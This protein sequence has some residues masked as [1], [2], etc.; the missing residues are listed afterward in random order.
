MS[1]DGMK[2]L[3]RRAIEMWSSNNN[4]RPEDLFTADYINHQEPDVEG[5][6][7]DKN[8]EEWKKLVREYHKSFSDSRV[9]ILRQV[10]EEDMV[11]THWEITAKHTGDFM[12][13]SS[14]GKEVSWRGV[15]IDKVND[16]KISESWVNWDKFSF[17]DGLGLIK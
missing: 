6:T 9:S 4:D 12:E 1:L 5:G 8:L 13:I 11:A 2:D 16:R 15:S 10:A 7:S 17:L 14:T 3:S